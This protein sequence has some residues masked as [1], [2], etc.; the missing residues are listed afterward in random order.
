ML[1]R[2]DVVLKLKPVQLYQQ[3]VYKS[4]G[5]TMPYSIVVHLIRTNLKPSILTA[6]FKIVTARIFKQSESD[7][8]LVKCLCTPEEALKGE[9]RVV[10]DGNNNG[11]MVVN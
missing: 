11:N 8:S 6:T 7:F 10:K 9:T 3:T 5:N 1:N 4:A 2:F